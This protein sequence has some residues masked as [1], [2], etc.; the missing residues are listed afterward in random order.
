MEFLVSLL[1]HDAD[2]ALFAVHIF[3]MLSLSTDDA[4]IGVIIGSGVVEVALDKILQKE[5]V[6][7]AL[8]CVC[9]L[10]IS[11]HEVRKKFLTTEILDM[12]PLDH[13]F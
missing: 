5:N 10:T 7:E 12:Y 1:H 11:N 9:N 2:Y 6:Y 8:L 3:R 4:V 13:L